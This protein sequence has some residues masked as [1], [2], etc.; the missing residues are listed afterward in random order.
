M[1]DDTNSWIR[2]AKYSHTICHRLDTSRL[3]PIPITIQSEQNPKPEQNS[4]PENNSRPSSQVQRNRIT[5]KQRSLSPLPQTFLNEV[6]REARHEQKRFST[7]GPRRESRDK[8]ITGKLS[9]KESREPKVS[10]SKTPPNGNSP[11]RQRKFKHQKDSSWTKYLENGGGGGGKV[12]SLETAEDYTID[13]SKLFLGLR[14]AHGAHSRL[15]HGEYKGDPVA[16]KIIRV[17]DDDENGALASKLEKQ[18]IREVTLLSR[19]HHSNV[20]KVLTSFIFFC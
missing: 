15:Y 7:P 10:S 17:P 1:E 5:N 8:R 2:R 4:K 16:V 12:A 3:N 13:M 9:N 6:F 11:S 19:L 18:F 14:F 20:I